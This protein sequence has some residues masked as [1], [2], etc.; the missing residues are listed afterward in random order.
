MFHWT[1]PVAAIMSSLSWT[2]GSFAYAKLG[3]HYTPLSINLNR[4][5]VAVPIF[6]LLGLSGTTFL[7]HLPSTVLIQKL[8][9]LSLGVIGSYALADVCFIYATLRL[10]SPST[11]AVAALYPIWA[12]LFGITFLGKFPRGQDL[13][14]MCLAISGLLF[15][16]LHLHLHSFLHL[17]R[18]ILFP[19]RYPRETLTKEDRHDL[20]VGKVS[21]TELKKG[22]FAAL[23]TSIFWGIN[24]FAIFYGG[25]ELTNSFANAFRLSIA[26]IVCALLIAILRSSRQKRSSH[27]SP[28]AV[29]ILDRHDYKKY[30]F[31][32][33]IEAF[34]GGFLYV[35]GMAYSSIEVGATFSSLSPV[36]SIPLAIYLKQ[37]HF[38]LAKTVGIIFVVLGGIL[39]VT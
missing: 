13:L 22:F 14:G 12:C 15:I 24:S 1:G 20:Q 19:L 2:L 3:K 38:S 30:L 11:Q 7:P 27:S 25:R 26:G 21:T 32:F 5:M 6:L 4:A 34:G 31:F 39:L 10:G 17:L 36:F 18:S 16:F 23:I 33:V 9:T 28:K 29:Y 8:L 37:E 35:H